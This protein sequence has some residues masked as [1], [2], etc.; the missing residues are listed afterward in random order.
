[1]D[2]VDGGDGIGAVGVWDGSVFLV[3]VVAE[4]EHFLAVEGVLG[5]G[6]AR[7]RT[8]GGGATRV[9]GILTVDEVNWRGSH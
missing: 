9:V 7:Q 8:D 3:N 5:P 4:K 2:L 6:D 1:M